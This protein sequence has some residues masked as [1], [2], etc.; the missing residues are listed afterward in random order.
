MDDPDDTVRNVD[1]A[2]DDS[3]R[4]PTRRT[5]SRD[6]RELKGT[7]KHSK[8]QSLHNRL[9][10]LQGL[11]LSNGHMATPRI[12]SGEGDG[13]ME[14]EMTNKQV[15]VLDDKEVILDKLGKARG[16][17]ERIMKLGEAASE[18]LAL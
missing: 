13:S 1:H 11:C 8:D 15:W 18:V 17:A 5:R 3:P 7:V 2:C 9:P 12:L 10:Q 6:H 14:T 4:C 16:L